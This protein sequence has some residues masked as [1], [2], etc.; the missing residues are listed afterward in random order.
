[1]KLQ[2]VIFS[3]FPSPSPGGIRQCSLLLLLLLSRFSCVRNV[4]P[5]GWQ[6]TG[7][8]RPWILQAKLLEWVAVSFSN[9][10]MHAC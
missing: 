10:C 9:A 2:L 6:P 3:L 1:M 4:R 7:L 8:L 5:H